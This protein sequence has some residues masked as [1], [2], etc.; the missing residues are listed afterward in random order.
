MSEQ[1]TMYNLTPDDLSAKRSSGK[2]P[3]YNYVSANHN[4]QFINTPDETYRADKISNDVTID[5]LQQQR[6]DEVSAV[7]PKQNNFGGHLPR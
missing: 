5:K 4:I 6:I 7:L 3:L 2:R 1:Y